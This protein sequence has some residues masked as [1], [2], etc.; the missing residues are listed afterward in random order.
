MAN[1]A[2]YRVQVFKGRGGWFWRLRH[3]NGRKLA[4]SESYKRRGSA[5]R[6][7]KRIATRLEASIETE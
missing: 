4:T 6:I 5:R 1:Q 3:S 2:P 7:A